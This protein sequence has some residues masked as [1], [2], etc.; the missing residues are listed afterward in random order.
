MS[1]LCETYGYFEV[2]GTP[3]SLVLAADIFKIVHYDHLVEIAEQDKNDIRITP[4]TYVNFY[5]SGLRRMGMLI[6]AKLISQKQ[7]KVL[8]NGSDISDSK[9]MFWLLVSLWN[10][11]SAIKIH[12]G[13]CFSALAKRAFGPNYS[14]IKVEFAV[15]MRMS[16]KNLT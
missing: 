1:N 10:W 12:S 5:I 7:L 14:L 2:L 15:L 11:F 3:S 8:Q 9:Q 13:I 6:D 4:F 16:L